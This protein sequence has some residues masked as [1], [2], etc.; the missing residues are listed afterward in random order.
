M[1]QMLTD[2]VRDGYRGVLIWSRGISNRC[3]RSIEGRRRRTIT[4]NLS[5]SNGGFFDFIRPG[6]HAEQTSPI[7]PG[8][9]PGRSRSSVPCGVVVERDGQRWRRLSKAIELGFNGVMVEESGSRKREA[10]PK[11]S[12]GRVV[13]LAHRKKT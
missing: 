6:R 4:D 11:A 5:A 10:V 8:M 2:A 7:T 3:K 9:G 13:D 12:S 1:S